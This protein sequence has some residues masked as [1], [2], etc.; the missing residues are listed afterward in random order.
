MDGTAN[1]EKEETVVIGGSKGQEVHSGDKEMKEGQL[2]EGQGQPG[3]GGEVNV[4][5][6]EGR[7]HRHHGHHHHHKHRHKHHHGHHH[8]K[9]HG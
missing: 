1:Q 6:H 7:P 8:H 3:S 2:S 9:H 4:E 5:G